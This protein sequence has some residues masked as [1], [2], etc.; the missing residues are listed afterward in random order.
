[1]IDELR[2]IMRPFVYKK[3]SE[4]YALSMIFRYYVIHTHTHEGE[5]FTCLVT[6]NMFH[7]LNIDLELKSYFPTYLLFK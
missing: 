1:M 7:L 4:T 6:L 5:C 3:N 2:I